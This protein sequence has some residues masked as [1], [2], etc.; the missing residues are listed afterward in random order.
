MQLPLLRTLLVVATLQLSNKSTFACARIC[1]QNL[2]GS[3]EFYE[4]GAFSSVLIKVGVSEHTDFLRICLCKA[5]EDAE[6]DH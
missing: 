4:P 3:V 5:L 2:P 1:A 6:K